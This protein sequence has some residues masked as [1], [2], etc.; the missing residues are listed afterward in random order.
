MSGSSPASDRDH[1]ALR[2]PPTHQRRY[3][4]AQVSGKV[5]LRPGPRPAPGRRG[6]AARLTAPRGTGAGS[7]SLETAVP[8]RLQP[9][10]RNRPPRIAATRHPDGSGPGPAPV[11][12][13]FTGRAEP[14]ATP[15]ESA[16]RVPAYR[17]LA[18]FQRRD[19]R[20]CHHQRL[21]SRR[22]GKL[23]PPGRGTPNRGVGPHARLTRADPWTPN[24]WPRIVGAASAAIAERGRC[25]L[26]GNRG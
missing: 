23:P 16:R 21:D 2:L 17:G 19:H 6:G 18:A 1:R 20:R 3:S 14:G 8:A 26:T 22:S 15:R 9:I 25:V 10:R 5:G 11:V 12:Y 4:Q 13:G 24:A 7:S